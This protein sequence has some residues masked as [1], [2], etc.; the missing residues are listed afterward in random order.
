MCLKHREQMNNDIETNRSA[1]ENEFTCAC[2]ET[3]LNACGKESV[4]V[5]R[6]GLRDSI[7]ILKRLGVIA[8]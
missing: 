6:Q 8:S 1:R 5:Y 2:L 4:F 7:A 3:L